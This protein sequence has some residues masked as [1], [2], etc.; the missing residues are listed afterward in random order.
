MELIERSGEFSTRFGR[1]NANE[2]L[3]GYPWIENIH[4]PFT[5]VRR[6]LPMMNLGL[7]SSA[8]AYIN[9]T[10]AFDL[11]SKGGDTSYREIPVEIE[12]AD[13]LYAA[14]GYDPKAVGED[15]NS[16]IPIDRLL[17]YQA[18]SVLGSLNSAWWSVSSFIP[19]ANAVAEILAPSLVDRIKFYRI[20]AV[21]LIP[22]SKLCHQT[23]GIVAR[24]I[25]ASGIPTINIS[26]DSKIT[27]QVRPPRT[28]YYKGN[29]GSVAGE[30]NWPEYQLRIVDETLRLMETFDQPGSRKLSV[31]QQSQVEAARGER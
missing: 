27:D 4:A 25:E 2:D 19:D 17:E 23:L 10:E 15:R 20:Q 26:V 5:P 21:L 18:N 24:A 1:W 8:G 13:L 12:A 29:F 16:L 28:A 3:T 31:I 11:E 6:A 9:G 14:K 30:P 7:I 22:A